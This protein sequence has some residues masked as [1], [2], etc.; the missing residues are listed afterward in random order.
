MLAEFRR[1]LDAVRPGLLLTAALP[2]EAELFEQLELKNISAYLDVLSIMAYDEHWS[3]EPLS[4][5][6]SA[7][8]HDPADPS[9]A[10]LDKRYGDYAVRGFLAAG[11]PKEKIVFGVPFYG[12]GWT[13]ASS[14]NHGLYQPSSGPANA[15]SYRK[16]KIL[17]DA[18]RHYYENAVTCTLW[19]KG[20]FWSYDCPEAMRAKMDY[21]RR[22]ELGGAMFWELSHDTDDMELLRILAGQPA[23]R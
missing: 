8:F 10:P 12:K 18:D 2:A 4:N 7:L 6:Q 23:H 20:K 19:N 22:L 14:K 13:V 3:N 16:L 21:I 11:V 5:L 15:I 17:R 1:Q 9:T